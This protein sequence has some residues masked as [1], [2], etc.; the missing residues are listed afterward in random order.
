VKPYRLD[1]ADI[2]VPDGWQ[3][4]TINAFSLEAHAGVS[5]ANFV[6]TRD[7]RTETEDVQ[8][9]SDLQL[10]A[11]AKTLRGYTLLGRRVVEIDAQPAIE[12]DYRWI[13]PDKVEVHQ[14][15]AYVKRGSTMLVLTLTA[16][17]GDVDHVADAWNSIVG[18]VRLRSVDLG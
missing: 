13:T 17:S 16:R 6:I 18:S 15:Q 10:V 11:A 14:R 1:D 5:V 12:V 9:Y 4:D 7:S 2:E 3:D 8:R